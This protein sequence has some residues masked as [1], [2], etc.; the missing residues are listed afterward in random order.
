MIRLRDLLLEESKASQAAKSQG[1]SYMGFGRWGKDGVVTHTTDNDRL[2]PVAKKDARPITR[3]QPPAS[4]AGTAGVPVK[5]SPTKD[6]PSFDELRREARKHQFVAMTQQ[7]LNA[8]RSVS[9]VGDVNTI[10][11]PGGFWFGVGAEWVDW[12]ESEM[13]QWKGDNL[14]AVEVDEKQCVVIEN[15]RDLR[16]FHNE[17]RTPNGMINWEKVARQYKGIIMKSYIP[18]ARMQ[19]PWYYTWD[20][21]S[22]CVWDTSAIKQVEQVP[23]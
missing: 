5:Q 20:I 3:P 2:L 14:Y 11:K 10:G 17:F 7:P 9:P 22:G 12:T 18:S 6:N 15:E 13:P 16:M 8:V 4:Q 19:Y 23:V 21:A 1:L